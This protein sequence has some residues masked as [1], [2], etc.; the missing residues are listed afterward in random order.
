M[1]EQPSSSNSPAGSSHQEQSEEWEPGRSDQAVSSSGPPASAGVEQSEQEA[2][3]PPDAQEPPGRPNAQD[4]AFLQELTRFYQSRSCTFRV[5]DC[6]ALAA[7][8]S[9][10]AGR[11]GD[12]VECQPCCT[13][14]CTADF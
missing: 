5:S 6:A 1:G 9:D 2:S 13:H 8:V 4:A 3:P 7:A 12:D 11:W 10:A 14:N